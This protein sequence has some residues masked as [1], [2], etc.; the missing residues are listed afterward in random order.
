VNAFLRTERVALPERRTNWLK[1]G[2]GGGGKQSK[3]LPSAARK[4]SNAQSCEP[5]S[6][7]DSK[8]SYARQALSL[9][10]SC[11]C[12]YALPF[13]P[14]RR[15]PHTIDNL[16]GEGIAKSPARQPS[17]TFAKNLDL[18]FCDFAMPYRSSHWTRR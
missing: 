15:L 10:S 16:K 13:A 8:P 4:G 1:E 11:V 3:I 17:P 7:S 12:V 9:T 6:V 18:L 2:K 5:S 14:P